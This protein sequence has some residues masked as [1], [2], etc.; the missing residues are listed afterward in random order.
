MVMFLLLRVY[1]PRVSCFLYVHAPLRGLRCVTV[2]M[3]NAGIP[4][5][6][7]MKTK[8]KPRTEAEPGSGG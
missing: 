8:Q 4:L 2:I 6:K 3:L 1:V 5:N 7:S